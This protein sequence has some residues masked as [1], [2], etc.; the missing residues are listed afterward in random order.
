MSNIDVITPTDITVIGLV[1]G[2]LNLVPTLVLVVFLGII[3]YGGFMRMTSAGNAEKEEQS[4]KI[5]TAGIVGFIIIAL[6]PF[7]I[8]ILGRLL[9][10]NETLLG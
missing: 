2:L 9:G 4:T 8:N 5:L 3:I 1:R 7:I 6:A 10:I